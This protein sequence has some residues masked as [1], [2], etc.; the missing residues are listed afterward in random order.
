MGICDMEKVTRLEDAIRRLASLDQDATIYTAEPWSAESAAIVAI[1][2]D[3]GGVPEDAAMLGL[4]YFLEVA[5]ARD[6]LEGWE[7]TLNSTPTELEKC[8]RLIR[9]AIDDA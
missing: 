1:E 3:S 4:K 8:A 7:S 2:P 6:F 9:Y 5:E